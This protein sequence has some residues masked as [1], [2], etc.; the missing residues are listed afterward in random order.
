MFFVLSSRRPKSLSVCALYTTTHK[1]LYSVHKF[2]HSD[3]PHTNGTP[4]MH[5]RSIHV[6]IV[7]LKAQQFSVLC[8]P[9]C[10][11][12]RV[13]RTSHFS[14]G[15]RRRI[16]SAAAPAACVRACVHVD[17]SNDLT[18]NANAR[19]ARGVR[20]SFRVPGRMSDELNTCLIVCACDSIEP[21]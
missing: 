16:A 15:G 11:L 21:R 12:A 19:F 9:S 17:I 1:M 3:A 4:R 10:A 18:G 14:G 5:A 8:S 2:I 6:C 20:P 13:C 7:I